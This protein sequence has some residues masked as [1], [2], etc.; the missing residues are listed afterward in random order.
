MQFAQLFVRNCK[1]TICCTETSRPACDMN[2]LAI[3]RALR[4]RLERWLLAWA[5]RAELRWAAT[6]L[7]SRYY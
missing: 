2:K 5:Q 3:L 7:R 6:E 4:P 1:H